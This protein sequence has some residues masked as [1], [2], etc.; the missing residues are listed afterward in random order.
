MVRLHSAGVMVKEDRLIQPLNM[1][2]EQAVRGIVQPQ[3]SQQHS[4]RKDTAPRSEPDSTGRSPCHG[5]CPHT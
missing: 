3:P 1:T 5:P 2:F 4:K